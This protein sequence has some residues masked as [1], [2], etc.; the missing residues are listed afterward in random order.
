MG[1]SR[2]HAGRDGGKLPAA[3][4]APS[5]SRPAPGHE[6]PT[7]GMHLALRPRTLRPGNQVSMLLGGQEAFPAMLAAIDGARESVCLETYILEADAVGERFAESLCACAAR[8]VAVRMIYD[9]FGSLGLS[10]AYVQRLRRAGVQ[11]LEY[12]PLLAWDGRFSL[13]RRDHRKILVVDDEVGFTG[14]INISHHYVPESEGGKGWHD[15][16]C[17]VR[18][19]VVLDLARLFR[20]VWIREGGRPYP[21]APRP[22]SSR[23]R[24]ETMIAGSA[25][26]GPCLARVLHNR[27]YR[28]RWAIRR[29][30]LHA[31]NR[32]QRTISL[33]NAYFLPDRGI[34][35]ALRR[36]VARGVCTRI[37]VPGVSD[38]PAVA[39]AAD[40]LYGSLLAHGIEILCW[41]ARMMHAKTAVI[42]GMWATIG[43][44]NLDSVSLL[45]N[46]EVAIEVLDPALGAAMDAQ[47]ER[48]AARCD[49]L[50]V[51][52]WERR[53]LPAKALSWL[54]YHFRH[55]L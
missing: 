54:L 51:E 11:V 21:A 41:P 9:A 25:A 29:A 55:W 8:G 22:M 47:F 43:S 40:H 46:L 27:E 26:Q 37:I 20:R 24:A 48:D 12:H 7:A 16:H 39:Y 35:W 1:G 5:E 2:V 3:M 23:A 34:C 44:Y 28:R 45:Y 10:S 15:V 14:G 6:I 32:A 19:P 33:M 53:S 49:P 13:N 30:Y 18:G 17:Q 4:R 36:A 42:D 38:V 52:G 31:I 50:S